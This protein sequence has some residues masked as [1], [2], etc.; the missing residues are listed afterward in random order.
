MSVMSS[1][2]TFKA[3]TNMFVHALEELALLIMSPG[4]IVW[5]IEQ[6]WSPQQY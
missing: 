1:S 3:Y 4:H 2:S 6:D 5:Y